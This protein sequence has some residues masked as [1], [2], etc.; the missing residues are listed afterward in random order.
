M[1]GTE[2]IDVWKEPQANGDSAVGFPGSHWRINLLAEMGLR[3]CLDPPVS[4]G[5][6]AGLGGEFEICGTLGALMSR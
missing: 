4:S 2:E 1:K 3:C 5:W 6:A